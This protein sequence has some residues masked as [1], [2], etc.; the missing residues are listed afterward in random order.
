MD[1]TTVLLIGVSLLLKRATQYT[2]DHADVYQCGDCGSEFRWKGYGDGVPVT[3]IHCRSSNHQL[4][5]PM[6]EY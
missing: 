1:G 5:R 4:I 2:R 3:C 6:S